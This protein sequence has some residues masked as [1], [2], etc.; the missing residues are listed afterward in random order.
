MA[1]PKE[2]FKN[3]VQF[4][5]ESE[6]QDQ[7]QELYEN[8]PFQQKKTSVSDNNISRNNSSLK[9]RQTPLAIKGTKL[10]DDENTPKFNTD[11]DLVW[12][13]LHYDH[14]KSTLKRSNNDPIDFDAI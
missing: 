7:D 4:T 8:T 13:N 5:T 10:I 14:S 9:E 3:V 6:D 1:I 11:L 2:S 12:T